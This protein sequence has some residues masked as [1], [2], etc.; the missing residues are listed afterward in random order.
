MNND[1]SFNKRFY[2]DSKSEQSLIF[3]KLYLDA[4]DIDDFNR[5]SKSIETADVLSMDDDGIRQMIR[6]IMSFRHPL[7]GQEYYN[8]PTWSYVCNKGTKFYRI[9]KVDKSDTINPPLDI[10]KCHDN[11]WNPPIEK[12]KWYGRLNYPN[13]SVLYT[14]YKIPEICLKEARLTN[15]DRFALITYEAKEDILVTIVGYF[16]EDSKFTDEENI[17]MKTL[18]EFFFNQFT[19]EVDEKDE[20]SYKISSNI[21]K[22]CYS[23]PDDS[24]DGW[25]YPSIAFNMGYNICFKPEIA[26]KKLQLKGVEICKLDEKYGFVVNYVVD[27]LE[28]GSEFTYHLIGSDKQK[29]LYPHISLC[30]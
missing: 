18:T 26:K 7:T 3:S 10:L 12:V 6:N 1:I 11:V 23:I 21:I 9:M 24:Q 19:K 14:S 28:R 17:K 16:Q 20:S 15:E 2:L 4:F 5:K 13:E 22:E 29:E 30:E 8:I 25:L 27:G